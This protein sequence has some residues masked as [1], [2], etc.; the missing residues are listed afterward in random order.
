MKIL[1]F[2]NIFD[3]NLIKKICNEKEWNE[4]SIHI[5]KYE[6]PGFIIEKCPISNCGTNILI[7]IENIK[8]KPKSKELYDM[9]I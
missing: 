6:F 9:F 1:G 8:N 2:K 4:Y 3:H 7:E 5:E